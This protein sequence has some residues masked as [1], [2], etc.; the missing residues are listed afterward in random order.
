MTK[1][2]KTGGRA[3]GVTNILPRELRRDIV[4]ALEQRLPDMLREMDK[5]K[6][7]AY[8]DAYANLLRIVIPVLL[9]A[10]VETRDKT[11][12]DTLRELSAEKDENPLL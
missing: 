3:K 9:A 7:K 10:Q 4:T 8:T 5:L 12:E 11:I 1:G 2:R 6:E